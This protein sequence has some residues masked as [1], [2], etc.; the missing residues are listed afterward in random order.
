MSK[1][2]RIRRK[3]SKKLFTRGAER[4]HRKNGLVNVVMRGGIRL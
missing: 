2:M 4:V 1:R 3:F